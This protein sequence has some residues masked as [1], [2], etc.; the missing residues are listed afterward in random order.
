MIKLQHPLI[1][2]SILCWEDWGHH[3]KSIRAQF[4]DETNLLDNV[5]EM[6][7]DICWIRVCWGASRRI[8]S[9]VV[10][11]AVDDD[12][13]KP[14]TFIFIN[15]SDMEC[16][17]P[18]SWQIVAKCP[19]SCRCPWLKLRCFVLLSPRMTAEFLK[20]FPTEELSAK[21]HFTLFSRLTWS[22]LCPVIL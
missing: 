8:V 10:Y 15:I 11:P 21:L 6:A 4:Y 9:D 12:I 3:N 1:K 20:F 7:F 2:P 22:I 16:L 18:L 13:L 5:L 19:F 14:N 17:Y